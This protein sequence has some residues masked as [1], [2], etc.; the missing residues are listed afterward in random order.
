MIPV[1]AVVAFGRKRRIPLPLPF[2]LLWPFIL[3]AMAAVWLAGWFVRGQT[4][5]ECGLA[6]AKT[7]LLA[8]FHLS[9]LWIDVRSR[10]HDQFLLWFL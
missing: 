3:L 1:L 2:F 6:L 9:G 10:D 4:R 7:A 8:L 5:E